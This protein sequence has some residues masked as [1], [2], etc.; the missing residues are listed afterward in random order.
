MCRTGRNF[1]GNPE[2]DNP[3]P[4]GRAQFSR[5]A[6]I[7]VNQMLPYGRVIRNRMKPAA[8]ELTGVLS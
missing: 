6:P 7:L 5:L 8:D 4:A 2:P 1:A 3:G